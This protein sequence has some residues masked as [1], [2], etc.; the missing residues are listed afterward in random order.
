MNLYYYNKFYFRG[1][2][3]GVIRNFSFFP[4]CPLCSAATILTTFPLHPIEPFFAYL[5]YLYILYIYLCM[6]CFSTET[7]RKHQSRIC[8]QPVSKN[9]TFWKS[10]KRTPWTFSRPSTTSRWN[11]YYRIETT[12][13]RSVQLVIIILCLKSWVE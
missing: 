13:E 5:L 7:C 10:K 11:K 8:L 4:R 1:I 6:Y 3:I 12:T 2:E 9:W